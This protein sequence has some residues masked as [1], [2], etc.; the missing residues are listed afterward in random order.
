MTKFLLS[1]HSDDAVLFAT[2]T[3]LREKPLVVTVTN[4]TTQNGNGKERMLED[5]EAMKML[6]LPICFL[7][8]DEDKLDGLSFL[9]AILPLYT[10]DI[11]YIPEYE[12]NGNPQHN[13]INE[14]SKKI[15]PNT[16]EYKTY[17]GLEDR[18]I[19]KEI[20][21]TEEELEIKKRV[22]ACYRTQ[23]ENP[24]TSHYFTTYNE[25]E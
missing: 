21:P 14:I 4:C 24:M 12:E 1:P 25:Y 17:S 3:L 18:T 9:K 22:M 5:I 16:K 13:L 19:G 2:Y 15:F 11:V 23:I 6:G 10:E 7:N 20:T 8:I